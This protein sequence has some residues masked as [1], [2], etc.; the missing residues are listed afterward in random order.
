MMCKKMLTC[1][2]VST[3][4]GH[5]LLF[6]VLVTLTRHQCVFLSP[7]SLRFHFLHPL[8]PWQTQYTQTEVS[9]HSKTDRELHAVVLNPQ[10]I[11]QKIKQCLCFPDLT[12][13]KSV[14]SF[15]CL[16]MQQH[17]AASTLAI[18]EGVC[19]LCVG[20]FLHDKMN[21]CPSRGGVCVPGKFKQEWSDRQ[22]QCH[23]T[24]RKHMKKH[25]G[26]F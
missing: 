10:L 11:P 24:H 22:F 18:C 1:I 12:P 9:T 25:D 16:F 19:I 6:L 5:Q 8:P 4:R 3:T 2:T 17:M 15:L 20:V 26:I 23:C 7:F 14:L 21:R 13:D